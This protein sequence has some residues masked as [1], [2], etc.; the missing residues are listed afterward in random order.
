[1]ADDQRHPPGAPALDKALAAGVV[2]VLPVRGMGE[3]RNGA[4]L[5]QELVE[6]LE[7]D[8]LEDGDILVVTSKVVSK[9]EGRAGRGDRSAFLAAETARVVARRGQTEIVRTHHGLVMAGAGIDASNAEPGTVLLLPVDPD[10]SAQ[11]L[12]VRLAALTGRNVG[13][14]VS[15][16]AGRAWRNGQ[17]DLA[18]GAAGVAVM[19]DYAGRQ[20]SFGNE[21]AVT[22][23]A[24]A[25]EMAAAADLV[26]GKLARRPAALLRGLAGWVHPPHVHG[27]GAGSLV[28][29]EGQDMFGFGTREAVLAALT[30]DRTGQAGFGRAA[31]AAELVRVLGVLGVVATGDA[32]HVDVPLPEADERTI[33]RLEA[34]TEAAA[35]ALGWRLAPQPGESHD[36][37]TLL[38]F[39]R[40]TP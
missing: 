6:A 22:A 28:R 31:D 17:V 15:D 5:A 24:V 11:A 1:M 40:S 34:M 30:S 38:R 8:G 2:L 12:R 39:V 18:V 29:P 32:G 27:S 4:D 9:A 20:D 35:F 10:A 26:K 37:S 21:L 36:P 19:H 25:D 14:V 33:G 7:P 3:I 13:V 16:T 23:P